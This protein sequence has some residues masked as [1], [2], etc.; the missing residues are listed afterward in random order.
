MAVVL[1]LSRHGRRNSPFYRVVVADKIRPR[2]GKFIEI[3]GQYNP[4]SNPVLINLKEDRVRHWV[5]AGAVPSMLVRN[6]IRKTIPGFIEE[7][8]KTKLGK[9]QAAR[10]ARKAR[11][12][13]TKS[14]K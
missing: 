6:L 10:K 7:R 11:A 12:K 13:K 5:G 4:R 8:E 3:V 9:I 2:D 14:A 1:R